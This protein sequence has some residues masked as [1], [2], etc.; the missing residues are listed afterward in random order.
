MIGEKCDKCQAKLP[1]GTDTLMT[2]EEAKVTAAKNYR[3][4]CKVR[5]QVCGHWNVRIGELAGKI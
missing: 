2:L 4:W 1:A 5:C 3:H